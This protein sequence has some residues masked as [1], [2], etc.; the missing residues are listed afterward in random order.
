MS[1]VPSKIIS[2]RRASVPQTHRLSSIILDRTAIFN[3]CP[4]WREAVE[5]IR[6]GLI[7]KLELSL[8]ENPLLTSEVCP[9]QGWTL[10]HYACLYLE[11]KKCV[12]VAKTLVK[13]GANTNAEDSR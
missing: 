9:S 6:R 3:I 13:H 10:L 11:D 4:K 1:S 7:H 2:K 12:E 5:A 8:S